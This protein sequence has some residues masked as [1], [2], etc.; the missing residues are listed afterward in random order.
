MT[1]KF[2]TQPLPVSQ[3]EPDLQFREAYPEHVEEYCEIM[4]G[5]EAERK[6]ICDVFDKI[7]RL[8]DESPVTVTV[9]VTG[10]ILQGEL[11]HIEHALMEMIDAIDADIGYW[12]EDERRKREMFAATQGS[13]STT[14]VSP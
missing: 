2:T 11:Q 4:D 7:D 13:E 8:P 3:R 14:D 9:G 6:E 1:I 12:Q 5:L 10:L